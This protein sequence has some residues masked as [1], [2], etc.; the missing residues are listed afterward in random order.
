MEKSSGRL[1]IDL[2]KEAER[3]GGVMAAILTQIR[4]VDKGDTIE[5]VN[6]AGKREELMQVLSVLK[7]YGALNVLEESWDKV[8]IVKTS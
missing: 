5:I 7:D 6:L 4:R 3:C 2:E 1:V 8:V